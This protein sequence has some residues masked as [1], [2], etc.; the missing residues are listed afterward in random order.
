[1]HTSASRLISRLTLAG[2]MVAVCFGAQY[3]AAA[4]AAADAH[5]LVVGRDLSDVKTLD[6][7]R[8]YELTASIATGNIYD[9]LVA[10]RGNDVSHPRPALATHW[11]ISDNRIYTFYLRHGVRFSNGDPLTAADVVF[12]YRRLGYL[13]DNPA[14]LMG[15]RTSGKR[16]VID[17]VRALGRYA[18]QFT[19]PSPDVSFLAA[20]TTAPNFGVL[21]ARVLRAHGGD[22]SPHAADTDRAMSWLNEHSIGTGPFLLAGWTPGASGQIVLR[23]NPYYWGPRPSL[24]Q[25]IFQGVPNSASQQLEIDRGTVDIA[26]NISTDGAA[27]LRHD[28]N[29]TVITGN[30]LDLIYLAMTTNSTISQPLGHGK[31]RQAI[32]AAV[33]YRGIIRGL[34]GGNG[35]QAGSM[36][37]LGMLGN[38]RAT[39]NRLRPHTNLTLARRLLTRAGYPHGFSVTLAYP[40]GVTFDGVAYDLLAPEVASDLGGVGIRVTLDPMAI[41][42][43]I[44]AFRSGKEA[45]ALLYWRPDYPD[46]NN[47]ATVFSTGGVLARDFGYTW[48]AAMTALV[49]RAD[50]TSDRARRAALY[51]QVQQIWLSEGPWVPIEQPKGIVVV[52]RGVLN[53][54]FSPVVTDNLSFVRKR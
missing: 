23:R 47:N 38:D 14:F 8:L 25:I 17:R 2:A 21:D 37:P 43:F 39:N 22:D 24:T 52:H 26:A 18:V 11:T 4:P 20:L 6:P 32:R 35:I 46:P 42:V 9:L 34:L 31:V 30:T 54:H 7:D 51:R 10:V 3:S 27:S 33:D 48:D 53:Y 45:L 44:P 36:I 15:A 12:S 1:V 49:T 16:V 19:L 50:Q 28:S 29:V 41:G 40:A 13:N 5:T